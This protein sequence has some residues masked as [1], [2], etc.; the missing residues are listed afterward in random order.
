M[1]QMQNKLRL[2][3]IARRGIS[4]WRCWSKPKVVRINGI[5]LPVPEEASDELRRSLYE[6][7]YELRE[8]QIL[9][10][11]LRSDDRVLELGTGLGYLAIAASQICTNES[12]VTVEANPEMT[13]LIERAFE[14][15][16]VRPKLICGAVVR[17]RSESGMATLNVS[18]DFWSARLSAVKHETRQIEVSEFPF[19][20][21]VAAHRPT[22]IAMDIEGTEAQLVGERIPDTVRQFLIELHPWICGVDRINDVR[23]WLNDE[24]FQ[25]TDTAASQNVVLF[26][27]SVNQRQRSAV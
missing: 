14:L 19:S 15:N 10:R 12:T 26:Q 23:R 6:G 16:Q 24:G 25:A 17:S 13:P 20:E 9:Q 21:L 27:R 8:F 4:A 11:A 18:R 2:R 22:F 5:R 7:S 3:S 1:I